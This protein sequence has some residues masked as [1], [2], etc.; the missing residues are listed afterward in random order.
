[1]ASRFW[2][3][4]TGTWDN[5]DTTHWAAT[6]GAAGGQSVPAAGDTV[7]FD[8]SS[9][10]GTVTVAATINGSNT[11]SSLTMGAFTGT[12]DFAAND[13]NITM[14][15]FSGTGTGTR[16]LSMGDGTWT[17]T[18]TAGTAWDLTTVTNLTFNANGSSLVFT[19]T[20]GSGLTFATGGRTYNN[21][22]AT[23]IGNQH[24]SFT[25]SGGATFSSLAL[26]PRYFIFSAGTT[27]TITNAF[28]WT[29]TSSSSAFLLSSGSTNG[30]AATISVASGTSTIAYAG[31]INITFSGGGTFTATNSF[32]LKG[33]TGITINGPAG[34]SSARVIGG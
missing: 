26:N 29:G 8:G 22:S 2:V 18:S 12:L 4:G 31:I 24:V 10:G 7:T 13:P 20:P 6:T 33:N 17:I 34:A 21:V 28:T 15:S 5:A 32:D 14:T 19:G 16:T 30:T 23:S 25:I 27:T 3:G 11:I 1:M 9:G